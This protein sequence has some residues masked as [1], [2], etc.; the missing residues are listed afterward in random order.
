MSSFFSFITCCFMKSDKN[1]ESDEINVDKL[2]DISNQN[3]KENKNEENIKDYTFNIDNSVPIIENEN[4]S[5]N[6]NISNSLSYIDKKTYMTDNLF[7]DTANFNYIDAIH[8]INNSSSNDSSLNYQML[9]KSMGKSKKCGKNKAGNNSNS[10]LSSKKNFSSG[11][12]V[13][14]L[15]LNKNIYS[16]NGS[17][18]SKIN[19]DKKQ[20]TDVFE[21]KFVTTEKKEKLQKTKRKE[22]NEKENA[23]FANAKLK[24]NPFK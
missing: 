24:I 7:K 18:F 12:K 4:K 21:N 13:T 3:L 16:S 19:S 8:S 6:D 14:T 23:K 5:S 15:S 22:L 10:F 11:I 1:I 20:K 17:N 2:T 9:D